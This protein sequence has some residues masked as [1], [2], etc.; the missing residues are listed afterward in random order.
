MFFFTYFRILLHTYL[1]GAITGLQLEPLE[2]VPSIALYLEL[3][4]SN[5]GFGLRCRLVPCYENI[6]LAMTICSA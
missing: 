3:G 6:C 5:L 1:S 2:E 4:L